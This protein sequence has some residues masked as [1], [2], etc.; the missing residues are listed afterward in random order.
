[1]QA[2]HDLIVLQERICIIF[3]TTTL[4]LLYYCVVLLL[5]NQ[6]PFMM[7]ILQVPTTSYDAN[8][9]G[10]TRVTYVDSLNDHPTNSVGVRIRPIIN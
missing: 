10:V 9:A 3:N 2:H 6:L 7:L 1:M 4:V 5:Q 8:T